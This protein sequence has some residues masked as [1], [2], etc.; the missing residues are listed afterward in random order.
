MNNLPITGNELAFPMNELA[1]GS[2]NP[3]LTIRQHFASM[4]M[5]GLLSNTNRGGSD[6]NFAEYSVQMAD[7]LI[8]EL[9][10]QPC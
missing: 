7:A 2:F 10:K 4:A 3:G 1:N 6:R 8:T 9:N 5:Q